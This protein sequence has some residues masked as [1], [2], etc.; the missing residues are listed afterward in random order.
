MSK[1]NG[2]RLPIETF[3]MTDEI[4]DKMRRGWYADEYFNNTIRV[5]TELSKTGYKFGDKPNDLNGVVSVVDVQNGDIVVEMQFFTR[6]KP[7]SV[8]AGIDE[9]LA[10]LKVG[11]GY[12]DENGAFVNTFDQLE[13]EAVEDGDIVT[14]DG[15]PLNVKPVMKVRGIYR[16]FGHLETSML[17]VL[18]V[19]TRIATNVYNVLKATK[20]KQVLFFPARFDHYK[21]QGLDGYAYWIALQRYEMDYGETHDASIST[22]EQGDWWGGKAGGTISHATIASF[23][24]N[25]AE[26]MMQ[27]SKYMPVET[28]RIVLVD[29]HNDCVADSFAVIRQMW[30]HYWELTKAGEYQEAKKYKL[31]GVR[32]DTGGNMRDK[33]I[34]PIFNKEL[35]NG[36]N[37][38]LV[39]LLRTKIDGFWT[40]LVADM[41]YTDLETAR[42]LAKAFCEDIKIVVTGGFNAEKIKRFEEVHA[43]VDIYGVGSS[44]LENSSANGTNNDYTADIVQVKIQDTFYPL[45][46]VGRGVATNPDL[47]PYDTTK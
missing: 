4:V 43:E 12:F 38:R 45:A 5:L 40:E 39:H 19:P 37:P 23:L 8:V 14:F 24:G 10:I 7:F 18:T 13:I 20:G 35:D 36:V 28:P 47:K 11:T 21:M 3:K 34:E 27:F 2:T 44:L 22:N 17:G 16:Y 41:N 1:F 6:R 33:S 25:T 30:N 46:K 32:P 26:T 9:A 15:D 31:F 42:P 29:F